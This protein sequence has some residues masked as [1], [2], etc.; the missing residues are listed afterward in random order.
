MRVLGVD[1]GGKRIGVAVGE[2]DHR[3]ATPRPTLAASGKL[4]TDADA[5]NA[6][7]RREECG[8]VVVGVP[9]IEGQPTSMS[10]V[11][12]QLAD[13]LRERG[14]TV[15]TVDE[16]LTSVGAEATMAEAGLKASQTRRRVDGEAAAR[17]LERFFDEEN[18]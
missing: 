4:A 8:A 2:S 12:G 17:I 6:L 11:C 3:I 13:R 7:A 9:L 16:S 5:L 15:H 18:L 14:W 10:R 1:F